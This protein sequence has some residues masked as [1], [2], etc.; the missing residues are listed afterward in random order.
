MVSVNDEGVVI[1]LKDI[2]IEMVKL[3]D[4]VHDLS[5]P[6][7]DIADHEQRLRALERWRYAVPP[8]L[9]LAIGST[10]AAIIEA[11]P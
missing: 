9:L 1:S 7:K 5:D 10:I 4:A 3:R 6:V 2:Y 11:K 8:A